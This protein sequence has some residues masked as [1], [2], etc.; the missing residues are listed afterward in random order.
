[1][2]LHIH[3]EAPESGFSARFQRVSLALPMAAMF[4]VGLTL[5][6]G[7]GF[8]VMEYLVV[9]KPGVFHNGNGE[10]L[11]WCVPAPPVR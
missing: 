1:M 10:S 5:G 2:N 8:A 4:F 9:N 11:R 7:M 6:F 3:M